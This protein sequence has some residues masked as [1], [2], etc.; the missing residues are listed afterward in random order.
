MLALGIAVA[1]SFQVWLSYRAARQWQT[2][3]RMVVERRADE[4]ASLLTISLLRDMRGAYESLAPIQREEAAMDSPQEFSN[5]VA[6]TFA[7]FP[8]VDCFFIW[9]VK[10]KGEYDSVMFSRADRPPI[11]NNIASDNSFPVAVAPA[12]EIASQFAALARRYSH[13]ADAFVYFDAPVQGKDYQVVGRVFRNGAE[14]GNASAIVGFGVSLD[15]IK[16]NYFSEF[17]REMERLLGQQGSTTLSLSIL[18]EAGNVITRSRP[19]SRKGPSQEKQFPLVFFDSSLPSL[20]ALDHVTVHRWTARVGA[21]DDPLLTAADAGATRTGILSISAALISIIGLVLVIRFLQM[22]MDLFA[23]KTN[24]VAMV[25]HELKTPLASISLVAQALARG[26]WKADQ[27]GDYGEVLSKETSRLT[28]LVENLLSVSRIAESKPFYSFTRVDLRDVITEALSRLQTQV[29]EKQA[30]LQVAVASDLPL[31]T[32]DRE[33]MTQVF[34]NLINN[35]LNYSDRLTSIQISA[36]RHNGNIHITLKDSGQ[37]I[38]AKDIPHVFG[39]FFRARNASLSGTGL[40]LSIV[41]KVVEDH[42]GFVTIDSALGIGTI[43]SIVL[44]AVQEKA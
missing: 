38:P 25:S 19:E 16:K 40:G 2:S 26:R 3:A 41:R 1:T 36:A 34:E 43:V 14:G 33:A 24:F 11:W 12:S 22:N 7:R 37:G 39:K 31:L 21:A 4:V 42:N 28:R 10:G 27:I 32:C 8:Y 35:A 13:P 44:P 5:S 18:D 20:S 15:W 9:R 6:R 23:M 17:T 29:E 30:G